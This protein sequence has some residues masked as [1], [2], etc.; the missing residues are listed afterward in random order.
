MQLALNAEAIEP[1]TTF[2][3]EKVRAEAA[4]TDCTL[5]G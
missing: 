1:M 3:Y 4:V 5:I 2:C